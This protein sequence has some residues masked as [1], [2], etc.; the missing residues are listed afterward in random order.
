MT[1]RVAVRFETKLHNL[2][3]SFCVKE[4]EQNDC[5]QIHEPCVTDECLFHVQAVSSL[6]TPKHKCFYFCV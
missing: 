3:V 6:V 5:R 2:D 4:V 1:I